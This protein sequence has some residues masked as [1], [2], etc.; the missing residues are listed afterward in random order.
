MVDLLDIVLKGYISHHAGGSNS[1]K[2]IL[3]A[4]LKDAP[5]TKSLYS[6][7]GIYGRGLQMHS[8]NVDKEGGQVWLTMFLQ[9]EFIKRLLNEYDQTKKTKN[10]VL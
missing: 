2:Y 3:P 9:H 5:E 4:I 6:K 8:L 7:S 1:L 10:A